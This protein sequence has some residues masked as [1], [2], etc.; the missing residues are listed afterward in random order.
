MFTKRKLFFENTHSTL[1]FKKRDEQHIV[2]VFINRN[3]KVFGQTVV[4]SRNVRH[5]FKEDRMKNEL[6]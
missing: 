1:I 2:S 5:Y 3:S 6:W 4:C